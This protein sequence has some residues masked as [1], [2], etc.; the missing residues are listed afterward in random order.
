[1]RS[2]VLFASNATQHVQVAMQ[3]ISI[4][5]QHAQEQ[6]CLFFSMENVSLH[7]Q[8]HCMETSLQTS[9]NHANRHAQLVLI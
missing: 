2:V 4:I 7:A 1:M 3:Q 6:P 8:T 5:A 9:V